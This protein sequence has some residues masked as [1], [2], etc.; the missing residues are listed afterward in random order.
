MKQTI[1]P[2]I[3]LW[4]DERLH[5]LQ[6]VRWCPWSNIGRDLL[7]WSSN[8]QRGNKKRN[9]WR[10]GGRKQNGN[11]YV[12][13]LLGSFIC[14]SCPVCLKRTKTKR[15]KWQVVIFTG[16]MKATSWKMFFYNQYF[17]S[18]EVY[19]CWICVLCI[20]LFPGSLPLNICALA[21]QM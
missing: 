9:E 3:H 13:M 5:C 7:T 6:W 10:K 21:H 19:V 4:V 2:A 11:F 14:L 15:Q 17:W 8:F 18:T 16:V 12:M 1:S 20:C